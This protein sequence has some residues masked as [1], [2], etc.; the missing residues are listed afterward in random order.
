MLQYQAKNSPADFLDPISK[1]P[2]TTPTQREFVQNV[3]R[4]ALLR[5]LLDISIHA[6]ST[7]LT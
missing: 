5:D 6:C 2:E 3:D 1:L 7:W 4:M